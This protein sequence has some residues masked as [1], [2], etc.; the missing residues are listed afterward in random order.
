MAMR[1]LQRLEQLSSTAAFGLWADDVVLALD[2]VSVGD[3]SVSSNDRQL[4]LEAA[5]VLDE[6]LERSTSPFST[7]TSSRALAASD[8]ALTAVALLARDHSVADHKVLLEQIANTLRAAASGETDDT[9]R[10]AEAMALFG[11]VGESQLMESNAVLTAQ[12]DISGW[13]AT[14]AISSSF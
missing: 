10:V 1:D 8:T 12:R 2:R 13:T 4:L 7:P 3:G 9:D 14:Q 6:A 11:I 5:A